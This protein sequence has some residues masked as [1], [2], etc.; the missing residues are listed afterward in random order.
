MVSDID[1]LPRSHRT[2]FTGDT[3]HRVRCSDDVLYTP[4]RRFKRAVFEMTNR[5]LPLTL[6]VH[7]IITGAVFLVYATSLHQPVPSSYSIGASITFGILALMIMLGHV[8]LYCCAYTR[9]DHYLGMSSTSGSSHGSYSHDRLWS[10]IKMIWLH[11]ARRQRGHRIESL[12][13]KDEE[14]ELTA[15]RE[16]AIKRVAVEATEQYLELSAAIK[17]V[18][19]VRSSHSA[20]RGRTGAP[21]AALPVAPP[22]VERL[23]SYPTK[24]KT[25]HRPYGFKRS[26]PKAGFKSIRSVSAPADRLVEKHPTPQSA[27]TH[28]HLVDN[29]SWAK[30][31]LANEDNMNWGEKFRRL[32][33]AS[34]F[35]FCNNDQEHEDQILRTQ[36]PASVPHRDGQVSQALASKP[37]DHGRFRDD[38]IQASA[39]PKTV[40]GRKNVP[41]AS[42]DQST[43][44]TPYHNV[45]PAP[46]ILPALP[47]KVHRPDLGNTAATYHPQTS[48][49]TGFAERSPGIVSFCGSADS[50][51]CQSLHVSDSP[52]GQQQRGGDQGMT[53]PQPLYHPNASLK[54]LPLN[55]SRT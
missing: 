12:R 19:S 32:S 51:I 33:I 34:S 21:Q 53:Q 26:K 16:D 10:K 7:C 31:V 42:Q 15:T 5:F 3:K 54:Q 13:A 2:A 1:A 30:T 40:F 23:P 9:H 37:D 44:A 22:L 43:L 24:Q 52:L 48:T 29:E 8:T 41:E 55:R 17:T 14:A 36:Q 35:S 11:N 25:V 39:M 46:L 27:Q 20:G 50:H 38:H 18:P 49:F 28:L 4:D 47:Q 6:F 45:M